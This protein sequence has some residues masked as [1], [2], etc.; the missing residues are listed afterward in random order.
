MERKRTPSKKS[1][2][3][4]AP[5]A[6]PVRVRKPVEGDSAAV[7]TV[8]NALL[9]LEIVYRNIDDLKDYEFNPRDNQD[10]IQFVAAS[11][12]RF[13]FINPIV[14]DQN[15]EII[16][17]HTRKAGAK[18][19]GYTRAP[20][21]KMEHLTPEQVKAFRIVDN[22]VGEIATWNYELLAKEV[23]EIGQRVD[24]VELGFAAQQIDCLSAMV[25]DDC[26]S[27]AN[28]LMAGSGLDVVPRTNTTASTAPAT[29]RWVMGELV[30][31]MPAEVHRAW[32]TALREECDFDQK[33]M[34]N[35]IYSKLGVDHVA[36]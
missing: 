27:S 5:T 26:L 25:A 22:K 33:Q 17:G 3:T 18:L 31:T 10:A 7:K 21:I 30:I 2:Q 29:T 11:I 19:V 36:D 8:A 9:D 32:I 16:I 12:R 14:I 28:E 24:L 1:P 34:T 6:K 35:M 15:D 23:M 20:T 4:V 13:G